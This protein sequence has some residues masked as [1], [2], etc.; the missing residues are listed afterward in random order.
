MGLVSWLVTAAKETTGQIVLVWLVTSSI[1]MGSLHHCVVGSVGI[2]PA[3]Y[4]GLSFGFSDYV[5]TILWDDA[6]EHGGRGRFVAL[7]KYTHAVRSG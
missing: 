3:V 6:G 5:A 4:L 2:L 1:G 7:L